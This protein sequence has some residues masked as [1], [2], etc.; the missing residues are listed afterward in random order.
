MDHRDAPGGLDLWLTEYL[1]SAYAF[2]DYDSD[3]DPFREHLSNGTEF[4]GR[5]SP[6]LLRIP[7]NLVAYTLS[8][9]RNPLTL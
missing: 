4:L 5:D 3:G 9:P 7:I 8:S 1:P 2:R 6:Q